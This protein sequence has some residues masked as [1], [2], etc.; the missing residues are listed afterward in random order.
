VSRRKQES[1]ISTLEDY[2]IIITRNIF[3]SKNEIPD[4]ELLDSSEVSAGSAKKSMLDVELVGTIVVND[5][6]RS[7]AA[8]KL[9]KEKKVEAFVINDVV[10]GKATVVSIARKKV[11]MKNNVTGGL[12]YIE[13]KEGKVEDLSTR[14]ITKTGI[15]RVSEDHILV[16]KG[17]VDRAMENINELLMQARAVPHMENGKVA[18]FKIFGIRPGSLYEKLGA[19]NGDVIKNVNGVDIKD[20]ASAMGLYNQLRTQDKFEINLDRNGENKTFRID[21]R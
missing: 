8:I 17:E 6:A 16:D 7:V 15:R 18:G 4:D 19:K 20:P 2:D 21:I 9:K 11:I 14:D 3:N 12:E 5:P 1:S 13:L 10:L